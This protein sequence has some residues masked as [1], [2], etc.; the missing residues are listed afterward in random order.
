MVVSD[1]DVVRIAFSPAEADA[2]L[3]VDPDAVL[4]RAVAS[5]LLQSISRRKPQVCKALGSIEVEELAKSNPLN[6][7]CKPPNGLPLKQPFRLAVREAPNHAEIITRCVINVKREASG[8]PVGGKVWAH[9]LRRGSRVNDC[10]MTRTVFR[11]VGRAT[12]PVPV[13]IRG[14]RADEHQGAVA[15]RGPSLSM[16]HNPIIASK[17]RSTNSKG[18][19]TGRRG[20]NSRTGWTTGR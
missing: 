16:S 2:P 1:V 14:S 3:G 12:Q 9:L 13:V 5:K 11:F 10:Y 8:L 7:G 6:F 15:W 18:A 4:T 17:T 19:N 20:R